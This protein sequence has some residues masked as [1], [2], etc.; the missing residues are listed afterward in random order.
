M[1]FPDI[2][3]PRTMLLKPVFC[4]GGPMKT[5]TILSI[6]LAAVALAGTLPTAR[7]DSTEAMCEVRKDG[8]TKKKASGP[9]SF[10]QRQGYVDIDLRNGVTYSLRPGKK[11]DHYKDQK[12]KNVVRTRAG[13]STQEFK[14]EGGTKIIVTFVSP[15]GGHGAAHS[16]YRAGETVPDLADLVGARAGQAEGELQRR[17]YQYARGSASGN[18]RHSAWFNDSTGRCAMI[19]TEDG[20][21]QSIVQAPPMDCGR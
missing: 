19:R 10:S 21:Y 1:R 2:R 16:S 9:C 11:A 15:G 7:A 6:S 18:A 3:S 13:G 5:S 4:E 12:G 14:W 20:R 17:G 8:D